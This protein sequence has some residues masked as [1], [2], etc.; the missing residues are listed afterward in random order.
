M[1]FSTNLPGKRPLPWPDDDNGEPVVPA[2][3]KH[4]SGG[5]LDMELTLNLL[6]AYGI[7]HVSGYP[8]DGLF[9]KLILG[10]SPGGMDIYVPATLLEDAQNILSADAYDDEDEMEADENGPQ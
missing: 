1:N 2:F 5:P 3:L 8:N 7:P 9:G 4:I 6:E 10:Y